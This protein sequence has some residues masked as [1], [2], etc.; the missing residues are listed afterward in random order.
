M[1]SLSQVVSL[2]LV[3]VIV[4]PLFKRA[5]QGSILGYIAAGILIGPVGLQ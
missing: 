2:L 3:A 1:S 5:G 4:V